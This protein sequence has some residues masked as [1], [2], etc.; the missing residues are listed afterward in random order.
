MNYFEFIF[1]NHFQSHSSELRDM[2]QEYIEKYINCLETNPSRFI[3]NCPKQ[4]LND[5][6][7]I[8]NDAGIKDE[9]LKILLEER[10]LKENIRGV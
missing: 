5:L 2:A 10:I 6:F 7:D 3:E 9:G 4:L 8:L 1:T